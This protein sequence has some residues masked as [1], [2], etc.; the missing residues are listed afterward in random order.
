MTMTI[1]E[2]KAQ[3]A[4]TQIYEIGAFIRSHDSS[5]ERELQQIF[6]IERM[7]SNLVRYA[8]AIQERITNQNGDE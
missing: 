4:M 1:H 2:N 3:K 6:E 7:L 8:N 5:Y